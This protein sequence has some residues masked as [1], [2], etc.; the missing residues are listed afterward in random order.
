MIARGSAEARASARTGAAGRG[1]A[2][3]GLLLGF[4]G[5]GAG[6]RGAEVRRVRGARAQLDHA[7]AQNAVGDLEGVIQRLERLGGRVELDQVVV[8]LGLL[9][10]LEG[11]LPHAPVVP[12][13]ERA[14]VPVDQALDV[15]DD[16]LAA[17]FLGLGVEQEGQ[18]VDGRFAGHAA[19]DGS[20]GA[21]PS[22]GATRRSMNAELLA[23]V[24]W[25]N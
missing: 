9:A 10:D 20:R 15:R 4:A 11:R 2:A 14:A 17:T 7:E 19:A 5:G 8:G 13:D 18:V 25:S 12:A 24:R 1:R 3:R 23:R 22:C 21:N 6:R 16:L